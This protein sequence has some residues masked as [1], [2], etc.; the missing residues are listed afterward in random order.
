MQELYRTFHANIA[1]IHYA[2]PR[3]M[4]N[5]V[6]I[7]SCFAFAHGLNST[8]AKMYERCEYQWQNYFWSHPCR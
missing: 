4:R 6:L 5:F 3:G 7:V 8:K 2:N 1:C